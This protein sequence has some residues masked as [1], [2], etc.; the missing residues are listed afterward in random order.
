MSTV[1]TILAAGAAVLLYALWWL[2]GTYFMRSPLDNIAG[3]TYKSISAQFSTET[4]RRQAWKFWENLA[5]TYG[6]VTS[7]KGILGRRFLVIHD[8]KALHTVM[9]KDQEIY[10]KGL[11]P[12]NDFTV[13]LGPGVLSTIGAQHKRQRKQ[14][15]P[16]F[17]AAHLRNMTHIF[18][19]V[20]HK[21]RN[22]IRARVPAGGTGEVLDVN[23]W[24]ARTTLEML[25][26][27]GL[28][29]SFDSFVGDA[30]DPYGESV[31]L[32]FPVLSRFQYFGLIIEKASYILSAS[33]IRGLLRRYPHKDVR[34]IMQ[35]S[36][37]MRR[38]SQEII[39]EKKAALR[40]GDEA[41][42]HQVGEGKDLMSI[43]LKA[44]M[45]ASEAEKLSDEEL[46]AQMSTFILAGMDTTSNA[47]SRILNLLAQNPTVQDKL[48]T[49]I[50]EAR[51]GTGGETDT[52]YDDL[53]KLPYLDAVCRETLRLYA[54][55][56]LS[57]RMAA[58]DSVIPLYTPIRGRDGNM[59]NEV[60]VTRG[61]L[62][63]VHY[64]A[65][66]VDATLWGEDAYEWKPERW[67]SPP[68]AAL[69]EARIPG[70]Y[71]NLMTFA[72][73]IRGCIGFKF[74]QLE[75]K[76]VLAVLLSSFSF[77]L[78]DKEITWNSSAVNYPTMGEDSTKPEML[79]RVKAL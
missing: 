1:L 74:S 49:E 43:C 24:M 66:N 52:P 78:T 32:F 48:R 45:T 29:Y 2:F 56:T 65:S 17:S 28:G 15:N 61:T 27:A 57:G 71:S 41:L 55:V 47:L 14:L 59:I 53:I 6:P 37:T 13:L 33:Q 35:I 26:Q 44:N 3:P 60:I 72:A 38:R 58:K 11:A 30:T 20:A 69:E 23:G 9:I 54:P 39:E 5:K 50:V 77:E 46:I 67:L 34:H 25:G 4:G 79:L 18:Y 21:V 42:L 12:L 16:V 31:K 63:L 8:P 73:G 36:D 7:M 51:G 70:V 40:K 10:V 64:Q 68:P 62:V 76:V 19:N 22:A 75:M